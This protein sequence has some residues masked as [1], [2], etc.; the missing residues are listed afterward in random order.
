LAAGFDGYL[1]KPIDP[2]KFV[3]QIEKYLRPE[4]R[5]GG[6]PRRT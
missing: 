6:A 2:G 4:L 5:S 1:S 3:A